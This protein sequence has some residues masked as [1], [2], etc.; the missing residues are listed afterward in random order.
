GEEESRGLG[1]GAAVI[2]RERWQL[3]LPFGPLAP[4]AM[5]QVR[6]SR[7]APPEGWELIQ[8]TLDQL[9][10]EVRGVEMELHEGKRNVES[11][12]P[13][14]R[15]C[16]QKPRF[17][18]DLF[19]TRKAISRELYEYCTKEK[20]GYGNLCCLHCIQTRDTNF[21]TSCICR[22]PKSK[23][24]VASLQ[25]VPLPCSSCSELSHL[26]LSR[27]ELTGTV[28]GAWPL[29]KVKPLVSGT[30]ARCQ[31]YTDT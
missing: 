14:F 5:P 24:E 3:P 6:R 28:M 4:K 9:G 30:V 15:L 18:F 26:G 10:Q 2:L 27:G 20:Q 19:Y 13:I 23:L 11:L 7:K 25:L 31:K 17:I 16:H 12:W 29:N 8:P 22:V 1:T 21:E